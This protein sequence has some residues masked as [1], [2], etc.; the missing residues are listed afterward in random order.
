MGGIE[1]VLISPEWQAGGGLCL[2]DYAYVQ[3]ITL[4]VTVAVVLANLLV[5][6]SYGWL[7]PRVRYS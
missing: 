2:S 6:I 5:D 4:I 1:Q 7:D 3:G